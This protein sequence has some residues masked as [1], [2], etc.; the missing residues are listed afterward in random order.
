MIRNETMNTNKR[1]RNSWWLS[2][3]CLLLSLL[4]LTGCPPNG[5]GVT[6]QTG[7]YGNLTVNKVTVESVEN[8]ITTSYGLNKT[9]SWKAPFAVIVRDGGKATLLVRSYDNDCVYDEFTLYAPTA[10][11]TELKAQ[12]FNGTREVELVGGN[13]EVQAKANAACTLCRMTIKG[14]QA[15]ITSLGTHFLLV[16]RPQLAELQ[17]QVLEGQVR[18][19]DR[20]GQVMVLDAGIPDRQFALLDGGRLAGSYSPPQPSDDALRSIEQG[21]DLFG[22]ELSD[23]IRAIERRGFA[24]ILPLPEIEVARITVWLPPEYADTL[25]PLLPDFRVR[26]DVEVELLSMPVRELTERFAI[27]KV[28]GSAPDVVI[29]AHDAFADLVGA[30]QFAALDLTARESLYDSRVLQAVTLQ[31]KIFGLPLLL[32]NVALVYNPELLG[33]QP[34]TWTEMIDVSANIRDSGRAT[35]GL[36]LDATDVYHQYPIF[37]A[38]GGFV[39]QPNPD[40]SYDDPDIGLSNAGSIAAATW[41]ANMLEA[42]LIDSEMDWDIVHNLFEQREAAAIITGPWALERLRTTG[43]PFAV[44]SFPGQM[45]EGR[46]FVNVISAYVSAD[47][48]NYNAAMTF[49]LEFLAAD[50]TMRILSETQMRP[51]ASRPVRDTLVDRELAA[52]GDVGTTGVPIPPQSLMAFVWE[53]WR[54]AMELIQ[55][56]YLDAETALN[57]ATENIY[58]SLG[59]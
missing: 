21:L 44:A 15:T 59:Q 1:T 35:Y 58:D 50:N 39:L 7:C 30:G 55:W 13:L 48:P 52:F 41:I 57:L 29:G 20:N 51:P 19:E 22:I 49:L 56:G 24:P 37:S 45:A 25:L 26:F 8:N 18:I 42:G 34:Q 3:T 47:T 4:I 5:N 38:F 28:S 10:G 9:I 46:P 40:G 23:P 2:A 12:Q 43:V 27:A 31:N 14:T 16:V 11:Q 54:E 33:G 6:V 17:V 32:E 36:A 53:P